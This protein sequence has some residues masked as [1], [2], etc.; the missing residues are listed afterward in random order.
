[1]NSKKQ[2]IIN[3]IASVVAFI[4]NIGISFFLTPYITRTIG[5]E[6]YGFVSLGSN[7][8]NYASLVTIA[9][10][11]MAGR[12]ITIEIHKDNFEAA[13]KY[14]NSVLIANVVGAGIMLIPSV[15]CVVYIDKIVNVPI[16]ILTDVRILFLF[17]FANF[18]ISIIASS[19]GVATFAT[20]KLYLQSLRSIEATIIKAILLVLLFTFLKPAVSFLGFTAFIMVMYTTFFN[21]YYTKKLLPQIKINKIYFDFKVVIELITS[22]MWNTII[23]VGQL[24]L[25][26]ID[27]L[28]ANL[29]ISS[30]VMGVLALAK[31][32]PMIITSF[33][34]MLIGVFMPNFTILYAQKNTSELKIAIKRSMNLMGVFTNLPIAI[35]VT[36]G[37]E[38]FNLWVPTQD[39]KQL[40][41]LS[42]ITIATFIVSGSINSIY[43]IFTVTNKL[44]ANA[45]VLLI[46]GVINIIIVLVLLNITD[47]GVYAIAGVSTVLS[48]LRNIIFTAPYGAKCLGLKWNTFFPEI[49]KSLIGFIL[50]IIIGC[51]INYLFDVNN[52]LT[53]FMVSIITAILGIAVNFI[54]VL[55]N[56]D[57]RHIKMLISQKIRKSI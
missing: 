12:F 2:L 22:G 43:G 40:Q 18:L 44:K 15:F 30:S 19:F 46:T 25:D 3:L 56:E 45:I 23:R 28:I 31:T 20:N 49:I 51:I 50:I 53:F 47:M 24:L 17:L 8:I 41:I 39:A 36:F 32:V 5:V 7:F 10:N 34:G 11:S 14:F 38:F 27:L 33:I 42:I 52:W 55:K 54:L 13:T 21:V 48:I 35:L 57:R 9:L 6:A 29:F 16:E 26:G 4:V 37:E 1:M